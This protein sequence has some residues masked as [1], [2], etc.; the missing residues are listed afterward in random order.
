MKNIENLVS[1]SVRL[2]DWY[3]GRETIS[4]Y[5]VWGGATLTITHSESADGTYVPIGTGLSFTANGS[6]GLEMQAGFLKFAVSG[7][8]STT[9]LTVNYGITAVK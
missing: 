9:A 6:V 1:N 7:G 8:G 3:G 5:G 4:A 2:A